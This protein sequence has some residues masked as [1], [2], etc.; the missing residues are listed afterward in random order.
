MLFLS[1]TNGGA[2]STDELPRKV[3]TSP[4]D[5][6]VGGGVIRADYL[7][8]PGDNI[9][10][11]SNDRAATAY[12]LSEL[13][14]DFEQAKLP[15]EAKD[16]VIAR[17][18]ATEG[19]SSLGGRDQSGIPATRSPRDRLFIR[20]RVLEVRLGSA[21]IGEEYGV[22]FGEGEHQVIFPVTPDQL[23][24]DYVVVIYRDALD[25]RRRLVGFPASYT[26]FVEWQ[27]ET[28]RSPLPKN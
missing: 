4:L 14:A 17:V 27:K 24:R 12:F 22:Y 13:P 16:L 7:S 3:P 21:T 8:G 15:S 5:G 25:G 18:R 28:Y 2:W 23:R 11:A 10:M 1:L 26:Q 6:L 9:W 20:V 19:T